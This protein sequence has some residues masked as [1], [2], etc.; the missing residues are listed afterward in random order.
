ME[1]GGINSQVGKSLTNLFSS[2]ETINGIDSLICTV[3]NHFKIHLCRVSSLNI[4]VDTI[5]FPSKSLFRC[6][7]EHLSTDSRG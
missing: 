5:Q 1:Q 7:I 2:E 4:I 6:G 3:S